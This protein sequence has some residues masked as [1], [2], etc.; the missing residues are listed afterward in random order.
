MGSSVALQ[1]R[2]S[3]VDKGVAVF[4]AIGRLILRVKT[5]RWQSVSTVADIA[6]DPEADVITGRTLHSMDP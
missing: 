5:F 4:Y 6:R 3:I 1:F 2:N